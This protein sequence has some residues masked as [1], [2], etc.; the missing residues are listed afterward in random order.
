MQPAK[1]VPVT[2]EPLIQVI[3]NGEVI[4]EGDQYDLREYLMYTAIEGK[5][6][7]T[8]QIEVY[9]DPESPEDF[10]V[11]IHSDT[12][13]ERDPDLDYTKEQRDEMAALFPDPEHKAIKD[14]LGIEY[15]VYPGLDDY[16]LYLKF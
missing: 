11:F 5:L 3:Q 9:C 16:P 7:Y 4:Y 1:H 10:D 2:K 13:N 12:W 8:P 15:K 6:G 14:Y